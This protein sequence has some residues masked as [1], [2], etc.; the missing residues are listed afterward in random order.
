MLLIH[1]GRQQMQ[2]VD[3]LMIQ[4]AGNVLGL[5]QGFTGF[6]GKFIW[7]DIHDIIN[8]QELF[9]LPYFSIPYLE[10]TYNLLS[11]C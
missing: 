4:T 11:H 10:K 1:Q 3:L 6:F 2:T 5:L 8:V 9:Q 7:I